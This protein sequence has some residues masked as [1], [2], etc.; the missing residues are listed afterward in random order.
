MNEKEKEKLKMFFFLFLSLLMV[1]FIFKFAILNLFYVSVP[2][3]ENKVKSTEQAEDSLLKRDNLQKEMKEIKFEEERVRQLDR[4][5][6]KDLDLKSIPYNGVVSKV[7]NEKGKYMVLI[8]TFYEENKEQQFSFIGKYHYKELYFSIEKK[9]TKHLKEGVKL[10]VTYNQ[11][12]EFQKMSIYEPQSD[13]I[14]NNTNP[15]PTIPYLDQEYGFELE[16]ENFD[17]EYETDQQIE[18]IDLTE[19]PFQR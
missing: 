10:I 4:T 13:N 1:I 5:V 14:S 17:L 9:H 19:E 11:D 16:S 6:F 15:N 2:T 3:V 8:D 18:Q 12:M 7:L